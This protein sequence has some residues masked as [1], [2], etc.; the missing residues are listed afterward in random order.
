[1]TKYLYIK[2][3]R[4]IAT[5]IKYLPNLSKKNHEIISCCWNFTKFQCRNFFLC[6]QWW[7]A[8]NIVFKQIKKEKK[9]QM[10]FV[11]LVIHKGTTTDSFII[12]EEM[13]SIKKNCRV[14]SRKKNHNISYHQQIKQNK[15]KNYRKRNFDLTFWFLFKHHIVSILY[16]PFSRV[17]S[18]SKRKIQK[19]TKK[20]VVIFFR[21]YKA[22]VSTHRRQPQK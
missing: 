17:I 16:P 18:P 10:A 15:Q 3:F 19:N 6:W 9:Y 8:K 2:K 11:D 21:G 1:M 14:I 7:C 12:V 5:K 13:D 20:W 22:E 4:E